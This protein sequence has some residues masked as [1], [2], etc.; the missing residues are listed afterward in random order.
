M[1]CPRGILEIDCGV[2]WV[3]VKDWDRRMFDRLIPLPEGTSYN[4]YLV[5]GD[6]ATVLVDTVNPGFERDLEEKIAQVCPPEEIDYVV[7]N[8]A[9]PDH[10]G[11]VK[12]VLSASEGARLLA[13]EGGGEMA[14]E[15]HGVDPGRIRT[16][17]DGET[18]DLGSDVLRFV[19]APMLHW[20]ETMFTFLEGTG[21]LFSGDFLGSHIA[22]TKFFGREVGDE[23]Y[24]RAKRYFGEIMMPFREMALR[25]LERIEDLD[26]DL[27]APSHGPLYRDPEGILERYA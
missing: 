8:H 23:T 15:M 4:S 6:G 26:V 2:Y 25:A 27:V 7:M 1:G 5:R 10:A 13:T 3:G 24:S 19:H 22:T 11:A 20:P 9:E 12:H 16:V 18:L 14:Q 21:V 17:S